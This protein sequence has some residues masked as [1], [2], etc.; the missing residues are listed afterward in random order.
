MA[1]PARQNVDLSELQELYSM[2]CSEFN[3]NINSSPELCGFVSGTKPFKEKEFV[4]IGEAFIQLPADDQLF[5]VKEYTDGTGRKVPARFITSLEERSK[6]IMHSIMK[7]PYPLPKPPQGTSPDIAAIN[8]LTKDQ[9][10]Q[11]LENVCRNLFLTMHHYLSGEHWPR[12]PKNF[13]LMLS[14]M[15]NNT[16]TY[17]LR[18]NKAASFH[19]SNP[20]TKMALTATANIINILAGAW[21][22]RDNHMMVFDKSR[23]VKLCH[24]MLVGVV[25]AN[26]H[27]EFYGHYVINRRQ[28]GK[29]ELENLSTNL[30]ERRV[31]ELF[32][33]YVSIPEVHKDL[34]SSSKEKKGKSIV[35]IRNSE[36]TLVST[37]SNFVEFMRQ[38]HQAVAGA[39]NKIQDGK[40]KLPDNVKFDNIVFCWEISDMVLKHLPQFK[41]KKDARLA[42]IEEV[43][44]TDTLPFHDFA[45]VGYKVVGSTY[46]EQESAGFVPV[47]IPTGVLQL[48][49]LSAWTSQQKLEKLHSVGFTVEDLEEFTTDTLTDVEP[50]IPKRVNKIFEGLL[51][52]GNGLDYFMEL[53][54]LYSESVKPKEARLMVAIDN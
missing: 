14:W 17:V 8:F 43:N 39:R 28:D 38:L 47:G 4:K 33:E 37:T 54:R 31:N 1:Q 41:K 11:F 27:G 25:A 7:L 3:R 45:Q 34:P 6:H 13:F 12:I 46:A 48:R 53:V 50:D 20:K 40:P 26:G 5:F 22:Y 36:G 51:E 19:T 44:V 23:K 15:A 21:L 42:V 24:M 52:P 16:T 10:I 29:Y 30:K 35:F 18:G 2:F 9:K 49:V 32:V